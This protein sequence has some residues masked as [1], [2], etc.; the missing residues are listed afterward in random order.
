[1]TKL[2][3]I[4]EE[5]AAIVTRLSAETGLTEAQ[6]LAEGVRALEGAPALQGGAFERWL[7]DDV[8][9]SYDAYKAHPDSAITG[10]ELLR[11]LRER[12]AARRTVGGG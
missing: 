5:T 11:R 10:D 3:E 8:A 6:V 1:M 7:H 9:A 4:S 2:V 12:S